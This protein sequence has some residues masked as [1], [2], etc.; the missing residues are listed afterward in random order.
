VVYTYSA[1]NRLREPCSYMYTPFEGEVFFSDYFYSRG[2]CRNELEPMV[3]R[4]RVRDGF[5]RRILDLSMKE[6]AGYLDKLAPSIRVKV[7]SFLPTAVMQE[8][9]GRFNPSDQ[10]ARAE[11]DAEFPGLEDIR[12]AENIKTLSLIKNLL[13]VLGSRG[14]QQLGDVKNW[15]DKLVQKFEVTKRIYTAYPSIPKKGCGAYDNMTVYALLA[16]LLALFFG[17]TKNLKYLNTVIKLNDLLC[18]VK[19]IVKEDLVAYTACYLSLLFEET[20][21]R[22]LMLRKGLERCISMT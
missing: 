9:Q 5:D 1:E 20:Y 22:E 15:I 21:V 10:A 7:E 11:G 4:N 16:L 18:S 6:M 8:Q 13:A 17:R 19:E 14:D 2:I 12:E 3:F